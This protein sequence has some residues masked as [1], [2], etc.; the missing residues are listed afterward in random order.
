MMTTLIVVA[1]CVVDQ[2]TKYWITARFQVADSYPIVQ[3]IFHLTYVRNT[4]GAFG[5]LRGWTPLL[6]VVSLLAIVV[7]LRVVQL[8]R[9]AT[10]RDHMTQCALAG[11][12]GGA[13]GNLVDRVR[14][15]YVIDFLDFRV[16]PVFNV[17]DSAITIGAAMIIWDITFKMVKQKK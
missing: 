13:L 15:G 2:L 8:R 16:W 6:I 10:T 17:A 11:V 5:M 12:L 4:G 9:A 14:V 3:G 7:M 1:V